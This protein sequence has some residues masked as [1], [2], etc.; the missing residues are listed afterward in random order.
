[1]SRNVYRALIVASIAGF[2]IVSFH[3]GFFNS[4][5]E[6]LTDRLFI[7]SGQPEHIV[8]VAVDETSLGDI[9]Q[10]PWPRSV[11]AKAIDALSNAKVIGIDI[12]FSEPSRLGAGDDANLLSAFTRSKV[13]IVLPI[14]IGL[15]KSVT[16]APLPEFRKATQ[17]GFVDVNFGP[18]GILRGVTTSATLK[19]GETVSSFSALI[20]SGTAM[21]APH[22]IR[23]AYRGP[24]S[25]MLTVPITDVINGRV[26]P[27]LFQ[28]SYVLIGA[29]AESLR[30]FFKTPFG[31]MPGVEV[32]ANALDTIIEKRYLIDL[33]QT[34]A[35]L[36]LAVLVLVGSALVTYVRNF[37]ALTVSILVILLVLFVT[38][39]GL[40]SFGVIVPLL[41]AVLAFGL[42]IASTLSY[43]YISESKEKQFIRKSFQQYL[44]PAVVHEL[45]QN[46]EKLALGGVK[47]RVT[48]LFSDIRSFTTISEG[49][50]PEELT[51]FMNEYLS[52][53]TDIILEHGGLVD[54]YIGDAIMAFWG[55]PIENPNQEQDAARAVLQMTKNLEELN[56]EWKSRGIPHIAIGVGL[57][58]GDVVVGNMGS[59]KRFDYTVMG[60]EVNFAS[61][62]EGLTKKYGTTCLVSESTYQKIKDNTFFVTRE[63]DTVRVKGKKESKKIYDVVTNNLAPNAI[64]AF[65]QGRDVYTTGKW[66][67]AIAHFKKALSY[68]PDVTS[69]IFI[70]RCEHLKANPPEHWDG[71]YDFDT[72]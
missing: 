70:E 72:K 62:L 68:G 53:M 10:W 34:L 42:S 66:D 19:S 27:D 3:F 49:M 16:T 69:E 1:M 12:D 2:T 14:E 23:I 32:H 18:D 46:P 38:A 25:T 35:W 58:T 64:T 40:F 61:R 67:E 51:H 36:L 41:Y 54:K 17:Q 44:S 37:L 24:G 26:P 47:K 59:I 9:G 63:L 7:K 52:A 71:V 31:L 65:A 33:P 56:Q 28:D 60:D 22:A 39:L 5:Q 48:V 21:D 15:E 6:Q 8:I 11:F 4:W 30:D 13:P 45:M 29:T 55:A 50:S 43:E 57:N 20:A